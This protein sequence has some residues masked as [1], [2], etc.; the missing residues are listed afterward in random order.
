MTAFNLAQHLEVSERTIYRDLDALSSAGIPV[1]TQPGAAG[2]VFLDEHYRLSLTGLS[3]AEAQSLFLSAESGPLRDLGMDRAVEDTLLKIFAALPSIHRTE[4]ERMRQ[5]FHI[6]PANWF[7]IVEPSPFLPLLQQAV[8]EDRRI[9]VTYQPVEGAL[10]QREVEAYG[11]VAKANIWYLVARK[12]GGEL[13]NYRVV[14]FKAVTLLDSHFE[15]DPDFDLATYWKASCES[16]ERH[17][18]ANFPKYQT[19]LRVHPAALWFFPGYLEGRYQQIGDPDSEGW[20]IL[21]VTFDSRDEAR[22]RLLGLGTGAMVIEPADLYTAILE[23]A[24]A[25]LD[26]YRGTNEFEHS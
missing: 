2:G 22:T 13:H 19:T 3:K 24:Q 11:L 20:Y 21:R 10:G 26:L 14:R 6:D 15:R 12:P 5:R 8:W 17:S 9:R 25:V 18:L 7:Q 16:F 23:T 4:V 1:Y